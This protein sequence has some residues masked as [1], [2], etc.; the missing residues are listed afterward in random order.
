MKMPALT[1]ARL[2]LRPFAEAD[3]DPLHCILQEEGILHYFPKSEPP[4][5]GRVERLIAHHLTH[6]KEHGYGRWAVEPR[7]ESRL[8]G[9]CGLEYL[10]ETGETEVGY[11]LSKAFWGRGLATEG[12]QASVRYGFERLALKTIVGITHPANIA[13]QRVLEKAG[14]SFTN[15]ARYYGMDCLRYTIGRSSFETK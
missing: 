5:R 1:T 7:A 8:I 10:P 13:S 14:L 3:V 6:W 4:E 9:W 11:L 12:A 15:C 2:T